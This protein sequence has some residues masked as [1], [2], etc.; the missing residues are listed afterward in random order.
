MNGPDVPPAV[1]GTHAGAG[2]VPG[3]VPDR[4]EPELV[5]AE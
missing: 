1:P 3:V 4:D 2:A 5:D